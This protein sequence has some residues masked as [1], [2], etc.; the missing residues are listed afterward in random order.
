MRGNPPL[1]VAVPNGSNKSKYLDR[2][3]RLQKIQGLTSL[4]DYV[5]RVILNYGNE[6]SV[7]ALK[8]I[9]DSLTTN[10]K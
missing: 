10:D 6:A 4:A 7:E 5:L 2:L 3:K 8:N 9:V 1:N